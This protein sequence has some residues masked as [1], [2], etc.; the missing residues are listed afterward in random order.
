MRVLVT[1]GAGDI[2]GVVA[3]KLVAA[4]H[5]GTALDDLSTRHADA[6]PGAAPLLRGTGRA[7]GKAARGGATAPAGARRPPPARGPPPPPPRPRRRRRP[8]NGGRV[9]PRQ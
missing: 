6:G 5:Q 1:G 2:G 8:E 9:R 3:A 7:R 4:G